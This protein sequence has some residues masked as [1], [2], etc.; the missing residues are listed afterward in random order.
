MTAVS[1]TPCR[2][3]AVSGKQCSSALFSH[4]D[5][6]HPCDVVLLSG[7]H[8]GEPEIVGRYTVLETL[9]GRNGAICG[10]SD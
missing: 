9:W 4:A 3:Q 2:W 10:V 6:C 8:R 1:T 7:I 5:F